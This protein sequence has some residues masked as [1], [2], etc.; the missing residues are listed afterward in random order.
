[1]ASAPATIRPV[2]AV[3]DADL[4]PLRDATLERVIRLGPNV[5][6]NFKDLLCRSELAML[7]GRELWK[8]IR[9]FEPEVLVGPGFGGIPLLYTTAMA[10]MAQDGISVGLWLVRDQ[11]KADV[12]KPWIT[13]PRYEHPPRTVVIDDF[14]GRGSAIQLIDQAAER[15]GRRFD[16][17]AIAVL[18]DN[19]YW[20]GSRQLS[21]SRCPVVSLFRRHELGLTRDCHDAAPPLMKGAAPPMIE[22]PL[23]SRFDF[24]GRP[25][26]PRKSSPVVAAGA[27]FAADDRARVWRF[28]A[29][30]G[31]AMWRRRSQEIPEKGIVQQLQHVDGSLVYGC[32]DGTVTRVGDERGD[33]IWRWKVDA[34][35]HATPAVDLAARRLFINT[36]SGTRSSP[37][38][39]LM[40]LD[41]DTGHTLWTF[42]HAFWA[43]GTARHDRAHRAVVASCNDHS[44]VCVDDDSGSLRWRALTKGLV[45]GQP[46]ITGNRVIVCTEDGW[47][48]AF[49]LASGEMLRERRSGIGGK[50]HQ[51]THVAD[52]LV[53]ALDAN[54]LLA[55]FD[56][57][58]FRLVWLGKLRSPADWAPQPW[59]RFLAVLSSQGEV[60]VFDT[61]TRLKLWEDRIEGRFS[62]PPA[63]GRAAGVPLFVCASSQGSLQAYRIHDHYCDGSNS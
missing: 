27:V 14:L 53:Y 25:D 33:L 36:E 45:R 41:W 18:Y 28:D 47:L 2:G 39:R 52:G 23:W 60:A 63:L 8:R 31:E 34:H 43:P 59:G 44:L 62:Q 58:D 32:Y 35:V 19:W 9:R 46:A 42:Q 11:R 61:A 38:G 10:A 7:A 20:I 1:M 5:I 4:A 54:Q 50:L 16:L 26:F 24:H 51:F 55:A 30:T 17:R 3:R 12:G 40:A 57:E 21:V 37:S 6:Y 56:T 48:Q 49:D 22:R 29:L 15:Q 13:G